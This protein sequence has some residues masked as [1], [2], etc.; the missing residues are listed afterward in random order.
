[1]KNLGNMMKMLQE[2]QEKAAEMQTKLE[3]LEIEGQAG[4]GMVKAT[5]NGKGGLLKVSIDPSL[6]NGE[7]TE[8]L[9][10]LIVAAHTDAKAKADEQT[11]EEMQKLTGGLPMPPGFKMPF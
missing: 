6:M 9:E 11:Q 7:E 8:V 4:G 5:V 1:M 2:A 3:S 10:D